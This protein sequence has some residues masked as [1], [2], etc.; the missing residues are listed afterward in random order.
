MRVQRS[1][2]EPTTAPGALPRS[3]FA[4]T[5]EFTPPAGDTRSPEQWARAV[6]EQAPPPVRGFLRAGWR[7]GLGLR[8]GP[9]G[10]STHVLGWAVTTATRHAVVLDARSRLMTARNVVELRDARV[11]WT[12]FVRFDRWPARPLWF[13]ALP[14]HRATMRHLLR[15]AAPRGRR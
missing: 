1:A 10:A 4:G 7:F 6:W 14:V 5:V 2:T 13:L 11:R 15:R 8:L 12:T 9:P 3:D